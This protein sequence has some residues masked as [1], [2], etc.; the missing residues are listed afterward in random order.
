MIK[1]PELPYQKHSLFPYISEDTLTIHYEKHHQ[2]YVNKL[3]DLIRDTALANLSL[4]EIIL[5]SKGTIFN[6]AAQVWNHTFYW[7]SL[8]ANHHQK[9]A[10]A[11]LSALEK[12]FDSYENFIQE[13]S[14]T[15]ASIFGSGWCW[16]VL[17]PEDFSLSIRTT[18]NAGL[19]LTEGKVA[20]LTCDVWE[21]AYYLDTKNQRPQ[22][23]E[24]FW[25]VLNWEQVS[26]RYKH[27]TGAE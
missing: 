3:N 14:K 12:H 8:S 10:G 15:A 17:D 22:Y 24:N 18:S 26:S 1:L 20:L 21:H 13:F 25:C 9:P 27:H 4:E 11:L 5:Q 16:L 2:T 19:P 23:I 7:E 6:N